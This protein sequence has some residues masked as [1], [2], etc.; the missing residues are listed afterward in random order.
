MEWLCQE[1]RRWNHDLVFLK[2]SVIYILFSEDFTKNVL[3]LACV[4]KIIKN[5][6]F[7]KQRRVFEP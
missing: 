1:S 4:E 6:D 7:F 5:K 3:T 2:W